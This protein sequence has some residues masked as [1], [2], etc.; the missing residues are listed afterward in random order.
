L[1]I[2]GEDDFL[3]SRRDIDETAAPAV[4][5]GRK[6]SLETLTEPVAVDLQ[7]GEQRRIEATTLEIGELIGRRHIGIGIRCAAELEIEQRHAAD[8]ALFDHPGHR[9][10]LAFLHQDTRHIGRDAE[11]DVDAPSRTAVPAPRGAR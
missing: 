9:A 4:T 6:E 11:A 10:M 3:R 5:C 2:A 7:E 1:N 8:R